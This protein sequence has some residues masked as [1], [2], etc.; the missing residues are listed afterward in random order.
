MT[1]LI[2]WA[3]LLAAMAAFGFGVHHSLGSL[4]GRP[5][6]GA[7][8]TNSTT[9]VPLPGTVYLA[10]GGALY[11]VQAGAFKQLTP[12]EGWMQ[13]AISPDGSQLV[14]VRRDFNSSDLY[15]LGLDGRVKAQLT[16]NGST[17][18]ELNHWAFFPRFSPD[19]AS[20][21]YSY[22]PKDPQNTFRVDL[23]VFAQ[24]VA[25]AAQSARQWSY[26]NYYTG[27]D[28]HPQPLKSG[29]LVYSKFEIDEAGKVYSQIWIQARAGSAGLALT[30]P[31]DNCD[32]PS[33]SPDQ[34]LL[35]MVCTHGQLGDLVVAP[36]D[37]ADFKLGPPTT[38]LAGKLV[39]APSFSPDARLVAFFA[40]D[41]DGGPFQLWT[42]GTTPSPSPPPGATPTAKPSP[43]STLTEITR[44]LALDSTSAPI[45]VS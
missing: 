10:Q 36:L 4:K 43:N 5:P 23:A 30:A 18:V 3:A 17:V 39:A 37:A 26:P 45:W 29:A 21:Y 22:D 11:R 34:T 19:G 1:R 25:G 13:P 33:L 2:A 24:P 35:L 44:G 12:A 41:T 27:G 28:V 42:M 16:H 38:L 31:T 6:S 40:P 15:L 8:A 32:Q 20:V 14:A 7:R 9:S